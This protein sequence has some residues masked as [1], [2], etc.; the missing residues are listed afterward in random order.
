MKSKILV[1]KIVTKD[2]ET[3]V[4]VNGTTDQRYDLSAQK[5]KHRDGSETSEYHPLMFSMNIDDAL[6]YSLKHGGG[7]G[8]DNRESN[9]AIRAFKNGN[10]IVVFIKLKSG[11]ELF[12]FRDPECF[13][14][15]FGDGN[16]DLQKVFDH[17]EVY[18]AFNTSVK[19][20]LEDRVPIEFSIARHLLV[21]KFSSRNK[22]KSY[23]DKAVNIT[24]FTDQPFIDILDQLKNVPLIL[25]QQNWRVEYDD[26]I[27]FF[28]KT[29]AGAKRELTKSGSEY[30]ERG[31]VRGRVLPMTL[32]VEQRDLVNLYCK[33]FDVYT[34]V[35]S[36]IP[37]DRKEVLRKNMSGKTR[38]GFMDLLQGVMYASIKKH[39]DGYYCPEY[40]G[41]ALRGFGE[42]SPTIAIFSNDLIDKAKAYSSYDIS[43][44][45]K[46][47]KSNGV[48]LTYSK[49]IRAVHDKCIEVT[50]SRADADQKKKAQHDEL[51]KMLDDE[52]YIWFNDGK[53]DDRLVA[54][55]EEVKRLCNLP[56]SPMNG[57][58]SLQFASSY[59]KLMQKFDQSGHLDK[60][61]AFDNG[62]AG[63]LKAFIGTAKYKSREDQFMK[64]KVGSTPMFDTDIQR[65]KESYTDKLRK[66]HYDIKSMNVQV[67]PYD[68]SKLF[69]K[70]FM[71]QR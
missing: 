61:R 11:V 29:I 27:S 67:V 14:K 68:S 53:L 71:S 57:K 17:K 28:N 23:G 41:A 20:D 21:Y 22:Y 35:K 49:M 58:F 2:P 10:D 6:D 66:Q 12:D 25:G 9:D 45:C 60:H 13:K 63:K 15:V 38:S 70:M 39:Y 32:T 44:I 62:L 30:W 7:Y 8:N 34:K 65:A 42:R 18:F 43:Q 55:M 24:F 59:L 16:G 46:S 3:C 51:M 37:A 54:K 52:K 31:S 36:I 69:M 1:E 50:K 47:L 40:I 48:E 19:N 64:P 5:F 26:F 56:S 33:L 4:W